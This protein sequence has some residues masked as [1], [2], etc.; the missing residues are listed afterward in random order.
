[1]KSFFKILFFLFFI[2]NTM[3]Q[4]LSNTIYLE[5]KDGMGF[6]EYSNNDLNS[7][8]SISGIKKISEEYI[9]K[10]LEPEELSKMAKENNPDAIAVWNEFGKHLGFA[11]SHF[12]NMVDPEM[13]S[14]GGGVSKAFD[15]FKTSMESTINKFSPSYKNFNIKI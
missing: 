11:L 12:I 14:I 9:G 1:M 5:L 2:K 4:D 6:S 10:K 3:A 7:Y 13:I 8:V 15:F